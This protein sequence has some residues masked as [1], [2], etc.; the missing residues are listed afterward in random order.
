MATTYRLWYTLRDDL[1]EGL[2]K[3]AVYFFEIADG[4]R[5]LG[6]ADLPELAGDWQTD[7]DGLPVRVYT[8][9]DFGAITSDDDLALF[10][11][12]ELAKHL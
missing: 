7:G 3:A 1:T 8:P 2:L 9:T 11:D 10:L 5:R 4:E 12:S 6:P